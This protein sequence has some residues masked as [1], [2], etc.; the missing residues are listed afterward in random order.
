VYDATTGNHYNYFRD[1]DPKLGRY[2]Q[3]DP[4]GLNGGLNRYGY[5][6]QSPLMYADPR[7]ENYGRLALSLGG[8][9]LAAVSPPL[10]NAIK[11]ASDTAV[12][13]FNNALDDLKQKDDEYNQYKEICNKPKPDGLNK[14]EEA[15]WKLNKAQKC[16]E[17]RQNWDNRW[18]PGRHDHEIQNNRNTIEKAKKDIAKYCKD[19]QCNE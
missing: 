3:A 5:V 9:A 13:A 4:I 10:Y 15:K 7:G 1:Y 11:D 12:D 6:G 14:C 8:A 2:I 17:L 19:G 18:W 16:V